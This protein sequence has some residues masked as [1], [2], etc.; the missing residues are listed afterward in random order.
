[1]ILLI[2]N[3]DSFVHNLARYLREAGEETRVIR[4]DQISMAG[5]DKI[6]AQAIIL[7]PGPGRPQAAGICIEL[8]QKTTLPVLGVCLGHQAIA[9]AWGGKTE[10]SKEP[11]HGRAS[12]I[13]H[14]GAGIF[15]GLSSPMRAGRYHSLIADIEGAPD[16]R[17]TAT[18]E[19]G[20]IMGLAHK[21]RPQYGVQFH[22]ESLL[23]PDGRHLLESFLELSKAHPATEKMKRS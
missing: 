22:P 16:L 12:E 1:M 7:S 2:D 15:A 6:G 3:Y 20:E 5:V 13:Y 14:Q 9:N 23:T 11:M 10:R 4:N 8:L 17:V 18:S 21:S 19:L